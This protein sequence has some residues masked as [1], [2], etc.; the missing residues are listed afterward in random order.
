MNIEQARFNMIQQQVRPWNVLDDQI[1]EL[2][3]EVKREDFCPAEH[4]DMAFMDLEIPIGHG[5]VMLTPRVQARLVQDLQLKPTDKVLQIGTGT[6]YMT[7]LLASRSQQVQAFEIHPELVKQTADNLRKAGISN[8]DL[9]HGDGLA[10]ALANGP[11]DAIVLC[12]S[13]S[14]VPHSLLEQLNVGGRLIAVVGDEPMMRATVVTRESDT[15][16]QTT[17]PW[18][19]VIPRLEGVSD[20]PAFTF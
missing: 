11:Y 13:V 9:R 3:E 17:Q 19:V 7:A 18:D 1:L 5:Q 6:G 14:H 20:T 8:V 12:G 4:R 16:F 2:L 15:V 10:G